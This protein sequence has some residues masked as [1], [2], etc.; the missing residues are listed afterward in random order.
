MSQ[1]KSRLDDLKIASPCAVSW[2]SM[3]GDARVRDCS[4]CRLRVY[5]LSAMTRPEAEKLIE[6]KEGRLCVRFF[7]RADGTVL[8]QD[9]PVGLRAAR[10]RLLRLSGAIAAMA[11]VLAASIGLRRRLAPEQAPTLMGD[12]AVPRMMGRVS[13]PH[14]MGE[15]AFVSRPLMGAPLPPPPKDQR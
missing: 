4:Q 11:G 5:N 15:A 2:D 14:T 1:I 8:T 7:R 6:E 12:V 13:A 3:T 10:L 9:C